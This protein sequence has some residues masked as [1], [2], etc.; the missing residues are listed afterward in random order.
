MPAHPW[1]F[2]W[3][4]VLTI[5]G[6]AI[7]IAIAIG[8]FRTFG[9]WKRELIEERRV[10]IALDVLSIAHESKF[11]FARI[12]DPNGFEGEWKTMPIRD[13]E[14]E[15]DR[16][17]RGGPYAILV[18]LNNHAD[19]FERVSR[20]QP[21]AIAVFGAKTEKAFERLNKAETFVRDAA[22]QLTWQLPVHP[23]KPTNENFETRMRLRGDLWAGF[24]KPDRVEVELSAFRSEIEAIFQSVIQRKFRVSG[25]F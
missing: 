22:M 19:Y 7:T 4:Q 25:W 16:S 11:V 9:R 3:T 21:K 5:I 15:I 17:R 2:G 23:E 12:R 14:N 10:N 13:G 6:F 20:L 1:E 24:Q 8:G 18:R